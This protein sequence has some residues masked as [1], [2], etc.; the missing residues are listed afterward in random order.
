MDRE[1][2][3]FVKVGLCAG[4]SSSVSSFNPK[5]HLVSSVLLHDPYFIEKAVEA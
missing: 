2:L 1:S 4:K 5:S 3:N